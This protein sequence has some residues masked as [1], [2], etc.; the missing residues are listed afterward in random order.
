MASDET[1]RLALPYLAAAQAQKHV[2][3][4]EALRRLDAYVQLALESVSTL[5]PPESPAEGAC[6][7][8][9]T[10]A[11][12]SF[13][14]QAG[15]LATYEAGA[16]DF[17]AVPVDTLAFIRD[18]ARFARHDGS[19][20]VSPLLDAVAALSARTQLVLESIT[21]TAPP[22]TPEE[23]ARWFVPA[24]A[25]GAFA[26]QAGRLA[27]FQDGAFVFQ[28]LAS[29]VLAFIREEWRLA[30]Y[31][32]GAWVSPLAVRPK[33]AAI[34][35]EVLEQD[36]VLSGTSVATTVVIPARAI[37]LGVSTRTL[38][39]VTGA[40]SFDCGIA[41][42]V[43]KFGGSLGVGLGA[44]NSGVVGPVAFYADMPVVLTANG[45]AFT[46]GRVRVSIHLLRCPVS[47]FP[48][49]E[50][51]WWTQAAHLLD[52]VAPTLAADFVGERYALSGGHVSS[53]S[54]VQRT[55]IA[56]TVIAA[57]GEVM[58]APAN[59]LA[60]DHGS[61]RRRMLLEGA[62][63]NLL[64]PSAAPTAAFS[65]TVTAQVYTLSFWGTGAIVLSG[66]HVATVNGGSGRTTYSFTPTAGSLTLTPSGTALRV[67]L[68]VGSVATSYIAT[69]TAAVTRTTDLCQWSATA[70]ALLST[71]GPNTLV[72][73]GK[74]AS[75]I[76][77]QNIIRA[78][79]GA[80]LRA[81]TVSP[82][83]FVGAATSLTISSSVIPGEVGAVIAW[84]EHGREGCVN[85]GTVY[86][87]SVALSFSLAN[88]YFG[89]ETGMSIGAV[90]A[91]DEFAIWPAKGSAAAVQ[92]QAHIYGA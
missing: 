32:G 48:D 54:L 26:G 74:I 1:A 87:D 9:P 61:G 12:G 51:A 3:H 35:A 34:E 16:F 22:A 46:G 52:G 70:A 59:A 77:A 75:Q 5:E 36:L 13:A 23:G 4:N 65:L 58:Q 38:S 86:S 72:W 55:G 40:T 66:A 17:L 63:T 49:L 71:A 7:F 64:Y 76:S 73:R 83:G 44:S 81:Q 69:T 57:S 11:T 2:T 67:Q 25:T 37:V 24:G 42:E 60:F 53:T 84:D 18:E 50:E 79:G 20:W 19:G 45:G 80:F 33:R 68:E 89:S 91:I 78:S 10:G 41:G 92:L 43:S 6:W 82:L 90:Y 85:A 30:L 14:G 39:G 88:M 56:K 31:D 8:V 47:V 15:K 29:G 21:D 27:V 62:A 28:A